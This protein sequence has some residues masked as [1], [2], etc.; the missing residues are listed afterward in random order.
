MVTVKIELNFERE[1]TAE[2]ILWY[3]KELVEDE[4]LEF[5]VVR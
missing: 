3:I 1:P 2:D 5:V 4:S